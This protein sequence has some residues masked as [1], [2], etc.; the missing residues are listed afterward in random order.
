MKRLFLLPL[1]LLAAM[2]I[3]T[4]AGADTKTV[5]ITK[6]GFTPTSTTI[7]LGDTVT[8]HNADSA[9]HQVVADN[10]SFA[11]PVLHADQ[12]Y[13][14]A[15][16]AAGKVA[17]HDSFAKSHKGS[18]TVNAPPKAVTLTPSTG[19]VTYG[20]DLTLS[21]A[22]SNQLTSEPVTLSSQLS[23]T[24]KATTTSA[25]GAFSFTVAPT[26]RTVY[27]AHW[28]T[29]DSAPVTVN[30]A[31]RIGFGRSDRTFTAKVTSGISYSGQFVWV[32]KKNATGGWRN[33]KRVFLGSSS[34]AKFTVTLAHGRSVLRLAL[35]ASQAGADYVASFS[36]QV[37]VT[38]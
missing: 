23:T 35:P 14:H 19:T 28:R 21:G 4:A 24:P 38:R 18:V 8:W 13:S 33:L 29:A 20:S 11:S 5:Q 2:L 16:S 31:P 26:V 34:N 6:N 10:G 17:Y 22:V 15:F 32:Q 12:S 25:N 30:V 7:T 37:V 3:A 27:T 36:R 9:D 1:A